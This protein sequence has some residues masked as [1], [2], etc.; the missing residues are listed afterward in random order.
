MRKVS[1]D[2]RKKPQQNFM[3]KYQQIFVKSPN[4]IQGEK[5]Q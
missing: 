2:F 3:R 5:Y 1:T 4:K